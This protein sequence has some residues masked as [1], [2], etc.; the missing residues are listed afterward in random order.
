M[1]NTKS[2]PFSGTIAGKTLTT[3][4]FSGKFSVQLHIQQWCSPLE[5]STLMLAVRIGGLEGLHSSKNIHGTVDCRPEVTS[6]T[7]GTAVGTR[8]IC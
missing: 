1:S 5:P 3:V 4:F 7:S 2:S 6:A 8:L